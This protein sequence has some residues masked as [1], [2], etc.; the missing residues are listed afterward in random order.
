[1]P[2]TTAWCGRSEFRDTLAWLAAEF[3][4]PL[5]RPALPEARERFLRAVAADLQA[6]HGA[7]PGAGRR[8]P[9]ARA[10]RAGALAERAAGGAGG[11]HRRRSGRQPQDGPAPLADLVAA[12]R[13]GAGR[14]AADPRRQPGAMTRR[15]ISASP[16]RCGRCPSRLHHGMHVRRDGARCAPGTCRRR[17]RWRTGAT[18][19]RATAPPAIVQPLIRPLYATRSAA[20]LLGVAAGAARPRRA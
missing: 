11:G 5:P 8:G 16:R 3:G 13:A 2:T 6:Q 9:A 10:A 19:A 1:M 20:T 14:Y 7:R 18:C 17:I 4:A 12:M 15:P